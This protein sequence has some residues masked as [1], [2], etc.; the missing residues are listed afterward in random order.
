[1]AT[2][3]LIR[4][5]LTDT[6]G[7]RLTGWTRGI[8]LNERGREQAAALAGRLERVPIGAIYSSSL[9]RCVETAKPLAAAKGLDVVRLDGLRDVNYGGWTNRNIGALRNTK[10]WSRLAAA[11]ADARFPDGE[12]LREVQSRMLSE[13]DAIVEDHP[14]TA[15]AVVS[16]ADPIKMVLAHYLGVHA[17]LFGRIVVHPASLSA[18]LVGTGAGVPHVLRVNDTGDLSDLVPPRPRRRVRG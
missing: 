18:V 15:V 17:D 12:S 7:K 13:V 8:H 14:R 2:L 1:M 5:G 6:A 4:H 3:L 16:H 9:E 11:P 10:L